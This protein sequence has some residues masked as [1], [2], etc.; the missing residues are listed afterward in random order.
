MDVFIVMEYYMCADHYYGYNEVLRSVWG[1][2]EEAKVMVDSLLLKT[3]DDETDDDEDNHLTCDDEDK[4]RPY[5]EISRTQIGSTTKREVLYSSIKFADSDRDDTST[6]SK[7]D[8]LCTHI[9]TDNDDDKHDDIKLAEV[10]KMSDE[11]LTDKINMVELFHS[12]KAFHIGNSA[13]TDALNQIFPQCK[14]NNFEIETMA[15][16]KVFLDNID[17][18]DDLVSVDERISWRNLSP[19]E[20]AGIKKRYADMIILHPNLIS[21]IKLL[22]KQWLQTTVKYWTELLH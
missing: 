5:L 21:S 22:K 12:L 13:D 4:H 11:M 10:V 6:Q 17:T 19:E 18:R 3:Y 9:D 15:E 20:R 16:L 8:E 14:R 7:N 1:S 2:F